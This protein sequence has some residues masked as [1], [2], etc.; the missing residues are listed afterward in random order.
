MNIKNW[1]GKDELKRNNLNGYFSY[2][3][4]NWFL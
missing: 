1:L 4:N 2:L 3:I